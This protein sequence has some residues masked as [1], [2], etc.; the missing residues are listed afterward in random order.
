MGNDLIRMSGMNSGLDTESI[1]NA[2]TANTKLKATKQE[3][4]VLKYE[5]TQEAY[6]DIISKLQNVKN[7]YFDILN[8]DTYLSGSSMWNKYKSTIYDA[9][10][11]EAVK[12]GIT[13]ATS[14]NSQPGEYKVTVKSTA[15][16][17]K[18]EG[19]SL[20]SNAKIKAADIAEGE[21]YSMTVNVGG[22][23][24]TIEFT[25]GADDDATIDSIN[26]ALEKAFGESNQS[27]GDDESNA[28]RYKGMVYVEKNAAGTDFEFVSRAGK[29]MT[30]SGTSEMSSSAS[31]D[32]TNAKSGTTAF[33]FQIDGETFNVNMQTISHDYFDD[34]IN[35]GVID[36]STG[37]D[38]SRGELIT[39]LSDKH[40]AAGDAVTSEDIEKEADELLEK[41]SDVTQLYVMTKQSYDGYQAAFDPDG[42]PDY[43]AESMVDHFT[44]TALNNT[45]GAL[46]TQTGVKFNLNYDNETDKVDI[47][48]TTGAKFSMTIKDTSDNS[49][50]TLDAPS[51]ATTHAISQVNNTTKLSDIG[52]TADA[53]GK[54]T[55]KINDTEFSFD[56]DVTV[57]E[58]MKKVN[59]SDAGVKMTFSSLEN[60]FTVTSNKYGVDS[61][62]TLSDTGSGDLLSTIGL[63]GQSMTA[64]ENLVVEING[65]TYQNDANNIEIDGT[66]FSVSNNAKVDEEFSIEVGKDT[67]AIKDV[68]KG[69]IEEY[70]KLVEDVYK[71][72][73]EKPEKDYYFLTDTDK[74]DLDLSE[75]QEEKWEEKSKKGLLYHDSITSS[76]MSGLRTAL[77]GSVEG[78][79]GN[80]FNLTSM[81]LKTS[82]DYNK[83]G[84]FAAIDEDKLDYAIENNLDDIQKLFT[85]SENGIMSK[86]Q[87][88]LDLGI[89]TTGTDKGSLI[90]KAGLSSG[91]TATNNELYNAIKRAKT[92]M[93]SLNK[94][95]ETE[96]NRLWKKY[97]NMEALLGQLNS[98]QSSFSSYFMQ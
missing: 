89:G 64:G 4:N 62:V 7:K 31:L 87:K 15:K 77:M 83:H 48:T 84:V 11:E 88:A 36:T 65:N 58:M 34:A 93:N 49:A 53:D 60:K 27:V 43:S 98:Q 50:Q 72:L 5:A 25:G 59:A 8:K 51:A 52:A 69:F 38:R 18:I 57:N 92:Q 94:R 96:Q 14:V 29:A 24:K 1:I 46:E 86:F 81:G 90:R 63:A 95:Y 17:A 21:K 97:S 3:R 78:L 20:S 67:S 9:S 35:D 2:L 32:F 13:V 12:S 23:E 19:K 68:I 40:T 55:F 70:N 85:D 41:Y 56:G 54:Y 71:Y 75:K 82:S 73:D 22:T 39:F 28:D 37:S 80:T 6:R 30:I 42:T 61:S 16:Q 10:G 33:Q 91:S 44:K 74:D 76:V 66:T 47:T 79:D 45:I 26:A